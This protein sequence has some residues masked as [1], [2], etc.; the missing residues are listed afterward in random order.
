MTIT[1]AVR[2]TDRQVLQRRTKRLRQRVKDLGAEVRLLRWERRAGAILPRQPA[3]RKRAERRKPKAGVVEK[4]ERGLPGV[5]VQLRDA[6]GKTV[7]SAKTETNGTYDFAKVPVG[8][9]TAFSFPK[10]RANRSSS[11][12]TIPPRT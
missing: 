11:S 2:S 9:N 10:M 4:Q 6:A 8:M 5:T 1:L 12:S 3:A 7:Q